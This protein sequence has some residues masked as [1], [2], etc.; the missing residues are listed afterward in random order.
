MLQ[1]KKAEGAWRLEAVEKHRAALITS[2]Q[3]LSSLTR[4]TLEASSLDPIVNRLVTDDE[5][6][7]VLSNKDGTLSLFLMVRLQGH[8]ERR[9]AYYV[10]CT[11]TNPPVSLARVHSAVSIAP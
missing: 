1:S 2:S 7:K 9:A 8:L 4:I 3:D 10:Y 11:R 6:H 5:W